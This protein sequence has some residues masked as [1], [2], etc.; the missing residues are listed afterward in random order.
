MELDLGL[1]TFVSA[2][3]FVTAAI[4]GSFLVNL[5]QLS[6]FRFPENP[7][8]QWFIALPVTAFAGP[9]WVARESMFGMVR[10]GIS[11]LIG[12][13]GILVSVIWSFCA[14]VFVVEFLVLLSII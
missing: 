4:I 11:Y 6:D 9:Y 12:G 14:G 1:F 3:G 13:F 10:G 2:F 8:A 7:L 5:K